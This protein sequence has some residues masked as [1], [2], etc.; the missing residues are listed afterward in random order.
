[1]AQRALRPSR[2][3]VRIV[4]ALLGEE[5]GMVGAGIFAL[6]DGEI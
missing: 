4:P 1:V 3:H 5:A 6:A 2:D